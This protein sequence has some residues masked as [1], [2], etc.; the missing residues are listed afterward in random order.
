MSYN[1][2]SLLELLALAKDPSTS[3]YRLKK[4]LE[5]K[6]N[7][8]LKRLFK[9]HQSA[10][11]NQVLE[12]LRNKGRHADHDSAVEC[13]DALNFLKEDH[14][15]AIKESQMTSAYWRRAFI[16][17]STFNERYFQ[18]SDISKALLDEYKKEMFEVISHL[19]P[20]TSEETMFQRVME[21][22]R[23]IS[24]LIDKKCCHICKTPIPQELAGCSYVDKLT[25]PF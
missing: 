20:G 5:D 21:V 9:N 22:E 24:E 25:V 4:C 3:N 10:G 23:S 12:F 17:L 6:A 7:S 18:D 14:Q 15:R 11:A 8:T 2:L 1:K 16:N 19:Y 13:F